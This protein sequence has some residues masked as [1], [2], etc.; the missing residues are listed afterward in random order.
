[1]PSCQVILSH[2]A[3]YARYEEERV[4]L[5]AYDAEVTVLDEEP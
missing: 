2:Y 5:A 1:M 3:G 4:Q